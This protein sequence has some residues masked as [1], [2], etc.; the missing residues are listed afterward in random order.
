[1][2]EDALWLRCPE[3]DAPRTASLPCS[4]RFRTNVAGDLVPL[5]G[6]VAVRRAPTGPWAAL[7]DFLTPLPPRPVLPATA[8]AGIEVSLVPSSAA[9]PARALLAT[10]EALTEWAA[11]APRARQARLVFA[12]APDGSAIVRGTPLPAVPGTPLHCRGALLLPCGFDLSAHLDASWV[13][14]VLALPTGA[15]ALFTPDG[16]CHRLEAE[17]FVPFSLAALRRTTRT[18]TPAP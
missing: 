13:E 10:L 2:A 1:M 8:C 16:R 5:A 15:M 12:A 4:A 3:S 11:A 18:L 14:A 7:V 6:R 9:A 17:A